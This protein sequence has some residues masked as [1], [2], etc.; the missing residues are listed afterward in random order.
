MFVH[1]YSQFLTHHTTEIKYMYLHLFSTSRKKSP[2]P[3]F[4][5][6]GVVLVSSK[7]KAMVLEGKWG[8]SVHHTPLSS[9]CTF[10]SRRKLLTR[11][12]GGRHCSGGESGGVIETEKEKNGNS[13]MEIVSSGLAH[14]VDTV[15][16]SE[17]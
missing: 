15:C 5:N 3:P 17:M 7:S 16:L 12:A 8:T 11:E 10:L 6:T 2:F 1:I 14:S 9:S 13:K 4:S